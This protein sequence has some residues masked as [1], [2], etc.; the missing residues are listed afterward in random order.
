VGGDALQLGP[1]L[2]GM[3]LLGPPVY[4]CRMFRDTFLSRYG[5]LVFL[6]G[7]H[8]QARSS[9]FVGCLDRIRKGE[10][11][12]TDIMFLNATSDGVSDELW[13]SRTQL[14]ALWADVSKFN[15]DKLARF[16]GPT[17]TNSCKDEVNQ[18]LKHPKRVAY[19]VQLLQECAP[20]SIALKPGAVVLSTR[21]VEGVMPGTQGEVVKCGKG[22]FVCVFDG[23]TVS[24]PF[25]AFD[26][27]DNCGQ[28]LATRFA[29]PL[30][31]GWA[32]TIHRAQSTS[33]F[34]LAI[35]FSDLHWCKE[36][37][38]YAALSRCRTLDG[39]FVRG[40][41]RRHVVA[42]P[43]ALEFSSRSV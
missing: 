36:G 42:C 2:K 6:L 43:D 8:R 27:V 16:A 7:S 13:D 23:R 9:W 20:A 5:S 3:D 21:E 26:V 32:M 28:R 18:A 15:N 38:V 34:K 25:V 37:L 22:K 30:V 4:M 12:D 14:R 29:I 40:L 1:I 17:T 24:G 41:R 35:D 11:T 10:V 31:L 19:A 39:F 33:L